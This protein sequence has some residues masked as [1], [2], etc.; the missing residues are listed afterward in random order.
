MRTIYK[1]ISDQLATF[2]KKPINEQ[3]IIQIYWLTNMACKIV[4]IDNHY[5]LGEAKQLDY[6]VHIYNSIITS[7]VVDLQNYIAYKNSFRTPNSTS[8][9]FINSTTFDINT[10]NTIRGVFQVYYQQTGNHLKVVN[11][12]KISINGM[13]I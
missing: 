7:K 1:I 12:P 11:I 2:K 3:T 4:Y 5:H 10:I 8:G 9:S 6:F 13:S